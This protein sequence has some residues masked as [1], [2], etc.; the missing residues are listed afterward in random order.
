MSLEKTVGITVIQLIIH[1][2][3]MLQLSYDLYDNIL[4]L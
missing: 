3:V 4:F 1:I 2:I